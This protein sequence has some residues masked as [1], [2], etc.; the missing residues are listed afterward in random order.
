M[1]KTSKLEFYKYVLEQMRFDP[2]LFSKELKKAMRN[3]T[4]DEILQLRS[5]LG[6]S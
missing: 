5:A 6:M 1:K 4:P 2:N 3:L